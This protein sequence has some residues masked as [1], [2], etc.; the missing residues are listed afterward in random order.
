[1][2]VMLPLSASCQLS[3]STKYHH[4]HLATILQRKVSEVCS[5]DVDEWPVSLLEGYMS[6]SG[7]KVFKGGSN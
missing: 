5:N 7:G 3:A 4:V 2:I 1:M 6:D